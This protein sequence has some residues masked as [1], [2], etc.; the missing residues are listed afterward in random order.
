MFKRYINFSE[1]FTYLGPPVTLKMRSRSPKSNKL[2][3]LSKWYSYV[4]LEK[5]HPLVQEISYIQDY[6]LEN[7]IKVLNLSK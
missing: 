2:L 1:I 4:S 7:G 6:D 3:R 5:I